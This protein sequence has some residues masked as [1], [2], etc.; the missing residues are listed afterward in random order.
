M[1]HSSSS[2][3]ADVRGN[4]NIV[5][6]KVD[7]STLT[8]NYGTPNAEAILKE[9]GI[10]A[11]RIDQLLREA[12]EKQK[13]SRR[14]ILLLLFSLQVSLRALSFFLRHR[15]ALKVFLAGSVLL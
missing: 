2:P 15:D 5:I 6:Q 3:Q 9:N 11:E 8:I 10:Q 1:T 14:M 7:G 13:K 12:R 4:G